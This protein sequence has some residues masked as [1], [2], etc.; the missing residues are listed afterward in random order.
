MRNLKIELEISL[1]YTDIEIFLGEKE[2]V[3]QEAKEEIELE[4][5][6]VEN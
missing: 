1:R 5:E 4:E 3:V 6:Q 2:E